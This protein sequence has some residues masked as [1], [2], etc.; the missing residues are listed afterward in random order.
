[1]FLCRVICICYL[2]NASAQKANSGNNFK[3]T[4]QDRINYILTADQKTLAHF[5]DVVWNKKKYSELSIVI[6]LANNANDTLKYY[7]MRCSWEDNY[8][9]DN[10]LIGIKGHNC[11]SNFPFAV[12][13]PPHKIAAVNLRLIFEKN[14]LRKQNKLKIGMYLLKYIHNNY[15][16]YED[17]IFHRNKGSENIIWSNSVSI[18]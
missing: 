7:S 15:N 6:T 13:I 2:R 3:L 12:S 4:D 8:V 17:H 10:K 16:H 11:D 18:P 1:M 14:S 9:I 5:P